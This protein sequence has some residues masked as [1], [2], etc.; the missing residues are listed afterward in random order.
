MVMA[1]VGWCATCDS[2]TVHHGMRCTVC[3][4]RNRRQERAAWLALTADE[5]IEQLLKRVE[6]LE[7]RP[8]TC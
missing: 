4:E 8:I 2:D 7:R 5:K 6:V 3:A 1:S